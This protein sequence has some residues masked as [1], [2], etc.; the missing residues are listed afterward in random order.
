ME[1]EEE[2]ERMVGR[3]GSAGVICDAK[4]RRAMLAVE[5]HL[6]L[7]DS[8]REVAYIDRPLDIGHGQTISAPHMVAIMASMLDLSPGMR[9][10]EVGG[11]SGYHAAVMAELVRP[12]GKVFS[13]ERIEGLARTAKANLARSGHDDVVQ[14]LIGDGSKGLPEEAPFDRISVAA[15]APDV[16]EPLIEQLAD[17]GMLLIPV[18]GALSQE[19]MMIR[20]VGGKIIKKKVCGVMFVPLVGEHGHNV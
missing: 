10:L 5:R 17:G 1:P 4:V 6:F 11:G 12:G 16:P 8:M 3:L 15:A 7:P 9:V 13:I 2:R 20:K 18:G 19:L 14:V